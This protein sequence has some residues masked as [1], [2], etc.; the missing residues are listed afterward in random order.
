[1]TFRYKRYEEKG[2]RCFVDTATGRYASCISVKA[3]YSLFVTK[4]EWEKADSFDPSF[5][6]SFLFKGLPLA[7]LGASGGIYVLVTCSSLSFL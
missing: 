2:L 3:K 5:N 1:M 4:K 6:Y 7:S